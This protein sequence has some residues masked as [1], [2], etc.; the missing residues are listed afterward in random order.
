[1]SCSAQ[2]RAVAG[3]VVVAQA[4]FASARVEPV[5]AASNPVTVAECVA[6]V[7][8]RRALA[9]LRV[10]GPKT[11]LAAGA[12]A[13]FRSALMQKTEAGFYCSIVYS[14]RQLMQHFDFTRADNPRREMWD[15][16]V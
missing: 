7:H 5:A 14:A 13:V 4:Q 8:P 1:M 3:P 15:F 2:A 9:R 10:T 11:T 6:Q 16:I 12:F